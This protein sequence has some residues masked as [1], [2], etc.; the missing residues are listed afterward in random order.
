MNV[1]TGSEYKCLNC[2]F[3]GMCVCVRDRVYTI[4][5]AFGQGFAIFKNCFVRSL[6]SVKKENAVA[7]A[8]KLFLYFTLCSS[9]SYA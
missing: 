7:E 6:F 1:V 3:G 4:S 8:V 2:F 9:T 5:F